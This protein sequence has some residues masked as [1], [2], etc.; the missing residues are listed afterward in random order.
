MNAV[1]PAELSSTSFALSLAILK[2]SAS[3]L[4]GV[5]G[6]A[7]TVM[8]RDAATSSRYLDFTDHTL[9]TVGWTTK[10]QTLTEVGGGYYRGTLNI[11]T[12]LPAIPQNTL[13]VAEYF[14]NNGSDVIGIS[15]DML[16]MV[17]AQEDLTLLRRMTKNRFEEYPATGLSPGRLVLFADDAVTP[18]LVWEIRDATGGPVTATTGAPSRR[19]AAT[20]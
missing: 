15:H 16:L 18:L 1:Y 12:I 6:Q 2:E 9:K 14:V 19:T 5:T 10:T 7:P 4:I 11:A 17:N 13:F 20:P 8:L 3:G